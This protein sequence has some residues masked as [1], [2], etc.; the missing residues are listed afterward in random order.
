MTIEPTVQVGDVSVTPIVESALWSPAAT[1]IGG[2]DEAAVIAA[3]REWCEVTVAEDGW[4]IVPV[5]SYVVRSAGQT[6]IVDTGQGEASPFG[7]LIEGWRTDGGTYLADLEAAG[8]DRTEV[9]IVVMT[10]GHPD[11]VGWNVHELAGALEPTF[12]NARYW[13]CDREW[14]LVEGFGEL[15]RRQIL[16]LHDRGLIDL[17]VGDAELTGDVRLR[18]THG[19]TPGH[20]AVEINSAGERALLI[21]DIVHHKLSLAD[22]E[23]RESM[24]TDD[25][26]STRQ[27]LY[28]E[29]A[30]SDIRVFASHFETPA[31]G[32]FHARGSGYEF[33]TSARTTS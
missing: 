25:A 2:Q 14:V 27:A 9:S 24:D 8:V 29:T 15:A 20:V 12:P 33:S 18:P 30:G 6:I 10:H 31:V 32:Y 7:S 17:V 28:E 4:V 16:S 22:P 19:H 3:T 5:R 21:G 13:L 1:W 23:G 26:V 11:H